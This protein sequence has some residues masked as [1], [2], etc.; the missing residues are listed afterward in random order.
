[1]S[2]A[3]GNIFTNKLR[4]LNAR[5]NDLAENARLSAGESL[6]QLAYAPHEIAA[7]YIALRDGRKI[8]NLML[9][10]LNQ[11]FSE[12][13]RVT[14]PARIEIDR[15]LLG[16][17]HEIAAPYIALCKGSELSSKFFDAVQRQL[18]YLNN[19]AEKSTKVMFLSGTV[20]GDLG[21]VDEVIKGFTDW[22]V[23]IPII[24]DY[25]FEVF[26]AAKAFQGVSIAKFMLYDLKHRPSIVQSEPEDLQIN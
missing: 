23:N 1:M 26:L 10:K 7:P 14:L 22:D 17:P 19:N 21:L 3:V 12:A 16:A 24:D 2:R 25:G 11:K 6:S 4:S 15:Q 20:V 9:W 8:A 13:S 5:F 18:K